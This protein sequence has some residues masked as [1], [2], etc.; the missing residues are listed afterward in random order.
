MCFIW[1]K[2]RGDPTPA[3]SRVFDQNQALTILVKWLFARADA[4]AMPTGL[5]RR[6]KVTWRAG[7]PATLDSMAVPLR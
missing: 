3:K 2:N 1:M 5:L 4:G 7:L 6:G